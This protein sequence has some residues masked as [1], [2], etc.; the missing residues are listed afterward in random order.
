MTEFEQKC[1]SLLERIA[2]ALEATKP[3]VVARKPGQL[4]LIDTSRGQSRGKYTSEFERFWKD[5]PRTPTMSKP[6][7]WKQW[8]KL[9]SENR[10][11]AQQAIG[12]YRQYLQAQPTLNAVHACRFLSQERFSGF[13]GRQALPVHSG[14]DGRI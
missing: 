1:L 11:A 14:M 13:T 9:S 7:A 4:D 8:L 2:D 3:K 6:E 10:T 12:P 5:Y